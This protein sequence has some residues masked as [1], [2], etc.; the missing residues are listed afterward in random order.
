MQNSQETGL[1]G[2]MPYS[3]LCTT[4]TH[5]NT[6]KQPQI[7]FG[8]VVF[9][10]GLALVT[11]VN[12]CSDLSCQHEILYNLRVK[13]VLPTLFVTPLTLAS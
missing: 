7:M 4:A 2:D 6:S 13:Q 11:S 10:P 5:E 12:C 8:H 1:I 9:R 3:Q